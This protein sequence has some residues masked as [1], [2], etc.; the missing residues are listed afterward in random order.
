[1]SGEAAAI[2]DGEVLRNTGLMGHVAHAEYRPTR[3][4]WVNYIPAHWES[5]KLKYVCR[6]KSGENIS[7]CPFCAHGGAG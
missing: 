3:I 1:M 4:G 6:M 7:S 5:R 2:V